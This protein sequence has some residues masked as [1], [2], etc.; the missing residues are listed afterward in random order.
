MKVKASWTD[1]KRYLQA[2]SANVYNKIRIYVLPVKDH[3]GILD[4]HLHFW[5]GLLRLPQTPYQRK[6]CG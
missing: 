5:L 3:L 4:F 1:L 2:S 6:L